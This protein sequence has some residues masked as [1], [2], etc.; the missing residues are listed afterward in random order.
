[1]PKPVSA[2]PTSTLGS[3]AFPDMASSGP[4]SLGDLRP[5]NNYAQ[6]RSLSALDGPLLFCAGLRRWAY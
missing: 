3:K 1:M 6:R 4:D 5:K 2:P